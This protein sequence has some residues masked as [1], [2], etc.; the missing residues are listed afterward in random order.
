MNYLAIIRLIAAPV[1]AMLSKLSKSRLSQLAVTV[2]LS[3]GVTGVDDIW[4]AAASSFNKMVAMLTSIGPEAQPWIEMLAQSGDI[5]ATNR[6]TLEAS[7]STIRYRPD[8]TRGDAPLMEYADEFRVISEATRYHGSL[9]G[10][11]AIR[12]FMQLSDD[13]IEAYLAFKVMARGVL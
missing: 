1:K 2:G 7:V 8:T 13:V 6:A 10:L 4:D 5:S 11:L 9:D 3:A 12:S